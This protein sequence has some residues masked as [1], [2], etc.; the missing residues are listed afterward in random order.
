M[1]CDGFVSSVRRLSHQPGS[2]CC[3][4]EKCLVVS[5]YPDLLSAQ[6]M[7]C[8]GNLANAKWY[9]AMDQRPIQECTPA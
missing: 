2:Q 4:L 7:D 1:T 5:Y 9:A 8:Q 3:V 6:A